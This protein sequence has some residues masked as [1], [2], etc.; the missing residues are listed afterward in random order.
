MTTEKLEELLLAGEGFQLEDIAQN[1]GLSRT[2][3]WREI[4]EIKKVIG[5]H[6]DKKEKNDTSL[7]L[8]Y[9]WQ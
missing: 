8:P 9:I 1:C 3:I 6:Y 2:T 4:Q 5:L 7:I